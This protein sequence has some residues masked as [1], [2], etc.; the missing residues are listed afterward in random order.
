MLT[1]EK[2]ERKGTRSGVSGGAGNGAGVATTKPNVFFIMVDDMGWND[3]GYQSTDL[4]GVTPNMDKLAA[5]GV[6]VWKA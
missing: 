1:E 6:K 2:E 5:G 4:V 3:I